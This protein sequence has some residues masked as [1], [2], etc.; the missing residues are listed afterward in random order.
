MFLQEKNFAMKIML[1]S[2]IYDKIVAMP[3]MVERLNQFSGEGELIILRTHIQED[4]LNRI[5]DRKKREAV[6][7]IITKTIAT[8]GFVWDKSKYDAGT[9]GDGSSTGVS[10]DDIRSSSGGHTEDALIATSAA[11]NADVLVTDDKR[12]RNRMKDLKAPCRIWTFGDLSLYVF[13]KSETK[14][15]LS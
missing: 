14:S 2:N 6:A 4:E 15:S 3:P 7:K 12:L 10:V 5:P 8:S 1:D 11:G 13:S 9:W